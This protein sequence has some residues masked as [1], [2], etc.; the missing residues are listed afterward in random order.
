MLHRTTAG[1]ALCLVAACK[2]PPQADAVVADASA[3]RG[4]AAIAQAGCAAC[5]TISGIAWPR[6]EAAPPLD[7]L[8]RRAL[9]AG[10]LPNDPGTLA[11]FIRN[12]PDLLPGTAMPAMPVSEAEAR[13]IAAYLYS[14]D[15]GR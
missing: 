9:I 2:A 7:G 10:R 3:E 13:D 15:E 11:R 6:G 14:M 12:A 4:K 5:H 8:S 1:I